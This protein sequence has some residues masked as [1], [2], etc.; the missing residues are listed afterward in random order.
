MTFTRNRIDNV[1]VR[2]ATVG[3]ETPTHVEHVKRTDVRQCYHVLRALAKTPPEKKKNDF[4]VE[5]LQNCCWPMF[6]GHGITLIAEYRCHQDR[7]SGRGVPYR[8]TTDEHSFLH[9]G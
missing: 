6:T 1:I 7:F 3:N 5:N 4:F 2:N 9:I 8:V